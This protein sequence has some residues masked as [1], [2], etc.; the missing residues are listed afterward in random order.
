MKIFLKPNDVLM[1][2]D[3][4]PFAGGEDHYARGVFPPSPST[5]YGALR[6]KILSECFPDFEGYKRGVNIPEDVKTV[7]G[8]KGNYG[9]LE[10][11]GFFIARERGNTFEPLFGLPFDV[12]KKKEGEGYTYLRPDDGLLADTGFRSNLFNEMTFLRPLWC[13]TGERVEYESGFMDLVNFERYLL[14]EVPVSFIQRDKICLKE[15]RVGI[16]KSRIRR[17]VVSGALYSVEYFRLNE[18]TESKDSTGFL[19]HISGDGG[20]LPDSGLLRLGGDHRSCYYHE[21]DY[22]MP[23]VERVKEY[24]E[25]R[26]RFKLILLT[27][28]YF[29]KG[30]LPDFVRGDGTGRVNGV[31][32][33]LISAAI[34]RYSNIGGFDLLRNRPK[35]IKRYVPPGSVYFFE[36]EDGDIEGIFDAFWLKSISGEKAKE[37]FGLTIIGGY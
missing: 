4:R 25:S 24:V 22:R 11:R 37:G 33:R 14:G 19:L 10:I 31:K 7:V 18:D 29:E 6:S 35:E 13:R 23:K 9:T 1:F 26:R 27:P 2:R 28:A 16:K 8:M 21:V 3:G 30:W 17:S 34:G 5:F 36:I 20:L 32:F 12:V 15:E